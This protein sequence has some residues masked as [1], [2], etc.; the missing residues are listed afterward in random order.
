MKGH[1]SVGWGRADRAARAV[2]LRIEI[3]KVRFREFLAIFMKHDV[4]S[5]IFV[6][7]T[8]YFKEASVFVHFFTFKR[9]V[10]RFQNPSFL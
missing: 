6:R 10:E 7:L 8:I 2:R 9:Y 5:R 3:H 1:A 4:R